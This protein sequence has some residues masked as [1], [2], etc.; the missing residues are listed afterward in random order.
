M[1]NDLPQKGNNFLTRVLKGFFSCARQPVSLFRTLVPRL[2]SSA[3]IQFMKAIQP[4][5]LKLRLHHQ[6]RTGN[7]HA[8]RHKPK[9]CN[10][11]LQE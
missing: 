11:Q 1:M 2:H 9:H 8:N 6:T 5:A 3:F 10:Q 4:L 7:Y